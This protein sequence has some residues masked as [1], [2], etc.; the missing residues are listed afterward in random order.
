M[1]S[2]HSLWAST[3]SRPTFPALEVD[4]LEVDVAV[5]G[6]GITGV[7]LAMLLKLAGQRVALLEARRLGSGTTQG[8]TAHLTAVLDTPYRVLEERFGEHAARLAADSS[9]RAIAQVAALVERF[10][11]TCEFERV[12]GYLFTEHDADYDVLKE[13]AEAASRAGLRAELA[14]VPLPIV[15]RAGVCFEGQAQFHPL[16]YLSGLAERIPGK[17]CHIFESSRVLTVDEGEPCRVHL[18]N[19]VS[20][21]ARR[22]VLATHA[23]LHRLLFQTK[24]AQYRSYVVS[25]PVAQAPRGLYWD[26]AEPYHYIRAA[27]IAGEKHLVVGGEDHKTGQQ[28][29][30]DAAFERLEAYAHRLGLAHATRRWSAQ[31]V[32]PVD[33]LPFIGEN[34]RSRHVFV[35]TGFSGNGMTFGVLS[36]MILADAC[37]GKHNPYAELYS[38]KRFKPL[39]A[40]SSFLGENID[41]PLHLLSDVA[42]PPDVHSVDEIERGEG[43]VA[44][45]AGERLAVYRDHAGALHVLSAICTHLG[46]QVAWNASE[47]TWDCPCHGSRYSIEGT[48]LDGPAIHALPRRRLPT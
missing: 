25:G 7:T 2:T 31:V 12:P 48:V 14:H 40:L 43:K 6:G 22:V 28:P 33:G 37:L 10:R 29:D 45:I 8:T 27:T 18:E 24:V 32:E 38:A 15:V 1:S 16:E 46:C 30:T 21:R 11:L 9:Q 35:A 26:T 41:Y 13:E 3:A 17:G 36:A 19:G 5:V 47:G 39:A 42:R 34:A 23:P 4:G 20:V 44:R